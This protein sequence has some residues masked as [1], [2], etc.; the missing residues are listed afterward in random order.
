MGINVVMYFL[1]WVESENGGNGGK[2]WVHKHIAGVT[3]IGGPLLGTPKTLATLL[4]GEMRDLT[5]IHPF[6]RTTFI[7]K[8]IPPTKMAYIFRS[9]YSMGMIAPKGG[10]DIWGNLT[11]APDDVV[12]IP[13]TSD[14]DDLNTNCKNVDHC[15]CKS[16]AYD[17]GH[18]C[19]SRDGIEHP[20]NGA[21]FRFRKSM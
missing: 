14:Y 13:G 21:V 15:H 19:E 6:F 12:T 8:L 10:A 2:N 1:R 18:H 11:W 20:T 16:D 7:E 5:D 9:F 3:N 17:Q 4:S